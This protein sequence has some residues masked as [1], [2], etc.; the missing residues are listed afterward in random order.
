M[1]PVMST[2][3]VDIR[4]WGVQFRTNLVKKS[5]TNFAKLT[6]QQIEYLLETCKSWK[7]R[8]IIAAQRWVTS[9][10][11][12]F[13]KHFACMSN[14]TS[15]FIRSSHLI[16]SQP[17]IFVHQP[18]C[19][20]LL[21]VL[22]KGVPR[23]WRESKQSQSSFGASTFSYNN[24]REFGPEVKMVKGANPQHLIYNFRRTWLPDY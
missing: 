24:N 17:V 4:E 3:T 23:I 20:N 8:C 22:I 16:M 13:T 9:P 1:S 7:S 11:K 21:R 15:S 2:G 19:E 10:V 5:A 12:S 18:L 6:S 14:L